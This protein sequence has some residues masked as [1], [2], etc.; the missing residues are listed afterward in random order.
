MCVLRISHIGVHKVYY[1]TRD[2][3]SSIK[4]QIYDKEKCEKVKVVIFYKS[5]TNLNIFL[6][7]YTVS[8]IVHIQIGQAQVASRCINV[9]AQ[10]VSQ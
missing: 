6:F 9:S 3:F 7:D 10:L 2:L 1:E 4:S 8:K 5:T